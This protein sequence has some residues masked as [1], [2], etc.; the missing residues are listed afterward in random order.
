[1]INN[2]RNNRPTSLQVSKLYLIPQ[3][4]YTVPDKAYPV[5]VKNITDSNITIEVLLADDSEYISTVLLPGWN[6]ELIVGLKNVP[7]NSLQA[8][9]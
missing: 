2:N 8:G 7:S 1:M 9:N 3:G 6:P 4:N 5:L